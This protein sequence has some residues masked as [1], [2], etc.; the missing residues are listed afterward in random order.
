MT[1]EGGPARALAG[2]GGVTEYEQGETGNDSKGGN[3]R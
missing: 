2:L 3:R 1:A